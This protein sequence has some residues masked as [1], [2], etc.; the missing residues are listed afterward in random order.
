MNTSLP[1]VVADE[2]KPDTT[3][4]ASYPAFLSE[5][6]AV[7]L[8][9]WFAEWDCKPLTFAQSQRRNP[10]TYSAVPFECFMPDFL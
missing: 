2:Q 6:R 3:H 1:E 4:D 5:R 8:A 10:I 7:R 9:K